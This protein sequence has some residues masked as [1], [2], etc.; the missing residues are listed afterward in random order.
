[1]GETFATNWHF[2]GLSDALKN[3]A[4]LPE[5]YKQFGVPQVVVEI[6]VPSGTEM[7]IGHAKEQVTTQENV[8]IQ[9]RNMGKKERPSK[10]IYNVSPGGG[11]QV[12][13]PRNAALTGKMQLNLSN[14]SK[15]YPLKN[16]MENKKGYKE[17]NIL[18]KIEDPNPRLNKKNK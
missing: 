2:T 14:I 13:I 11:V 12:L 7:Y 5:W 1:M 16:D 10:R 9:K 17:T 3:M 4:L 6:F 15:T 8:S 18:K